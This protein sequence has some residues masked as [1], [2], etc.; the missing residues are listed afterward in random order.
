MLYV[1][2]EWLSTWSPVFI[3]LIFFWVIWFI[4]IR[5]FKWGA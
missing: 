3:G 2:G 5:A 1:F 4:I